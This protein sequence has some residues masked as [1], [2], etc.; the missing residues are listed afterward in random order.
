[1]RVGIGFEDVAAVDAGEEAAVDGRGEEAAVFLDEDVVDGGFG[2]FVALIEK[3]DFVVAGLDC[4][5]EGLRVE[6]AMG[7]FVEVHGVSRVGS[8]CGDADSEGLTGGG[9]DW[10][11]RDLEGAVG[12][13]EETDFVGCLGLIQRVSL[14]CAEMAS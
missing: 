11:G 2:D 12:V 6:G 4:C 14:R 10:L 5:L 7:G 9:C 8:F 1:M 3:E 13:Q